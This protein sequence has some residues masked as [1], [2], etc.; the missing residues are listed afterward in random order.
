MTANEMGVIIV[1]FILLIFFLCICDIETRIE[2]RSVFPASIIAQRKQ[3]G[4]MRT[5]IDF[6]FLR[7]IQLRVQHFDASMKCL[8][9]FY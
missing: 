8:I 9:G 7:F 3:F 2:K 6:Y 1:C 4:N 5:K